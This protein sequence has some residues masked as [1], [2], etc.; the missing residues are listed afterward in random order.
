MILPQAILNSLSFYEETSVEIDG[1]F[2]TKFTLH[3][4]Q[5]WKFKRV[6]LIRY[7]RAKLDNNQVT[8]EETAS[9][10][11]LKDQ[12]KRYFAQSSNGW[13]TVI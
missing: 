11:E 5:W 6:M 4:K 12:L 7:R 1:T 13:N 9:C 2:Y 8:W 3:F 10:V